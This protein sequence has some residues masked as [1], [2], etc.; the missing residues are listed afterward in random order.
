MAERVASRVFAGRAG[1]FGELAAA[2]ARAA[3]GTPLVVLVGGEAGVGK[4][5]LLSEVAGR[6]A[7]DGARVLWGECVGLEEAAIP[8][9]PVT[10]A[11]SALD[12]GGATAP[13]ATPLVRGP[14]ARPH[15]C[16]LERLAQTSASVPVLLVVEDLHWADRS[17]LDCVTFLARR[18]RRE[19]VLVVASFRSD[20]VAR[21]GGLRRFLADIST[22][23]N[24]RRL[25]LTGLTRDEMRM[26]IGGIAGTPASAEL[27]DALF[28][29]SG[30]NPFF[31]EELLA[32][33]R[34]GSAAG[35]SLALRDMLLARI[36]ALP[37]GAQVVVRVAAVGGRHVHH[38]LLADAAGLPEAQLT[39]ALRAAVRH[40]VLVARDDDFAFRHALV[41]EVAYGELLPGE[42]GRL[43]AAF[44]GALEGRPDVSGGSPA[45]VAAEVAHHWL[46]AGDHHRA[47]RATV[48]AGTEAERVGALAE[49]ARQHTRALALW[50]AVP[51]AER[52]AGLDQAGL[53]ARAANAIAS[54]ADAAEAIRL[55][56]R[57]IELVDAEA[58]PLR[59]ALLHERR[60]MFLWQLE[61]GLEGVR[62]FERAVELIPS[63]PPSA[64]WATALGRLGWILMLTGEHVRSRE[65]C[66]A[67]VAVAR[68]VGARVAEADALAT[69]GI[70]LGLL[71]DGPG[72]L[73]CLRRA[74]ALAAEAGDSEIL[75]QT[76]IALSAGLMRDGQ[77]ADAVEVALAGA[78]AS[79]RA[80]LDARE[81]FCLMQAAEAA[82]ELGSW[83]TVD[84]L[85]REV[86]ARELTGI[87]LTNAHHMAG[88]LAC[89]RGDL[90][91][92]EAH[93]A[94]ERDAI[95]AHPT[96]ESGSYA[97]EAE[98]ELALAQRRPKAASRAAERGTRV[99]TADKERCL[100]MSAI[101][102]RA[103]ADLAEI[104]RA[105]RDRPA[106]L[107]ARQQARAFHDLGGEL[108]AGAGHAALSALIEAEHARAEGDSDPV[109]WDA[110]ARAWEGRSAP[111]RAAYARR[112]QAEAALEHRD[113][114]QAA[115]ALRAA[116][117]TAVDLG[118]T[119]L[120]SDIER[121]ARRA[122][123]DL[124]ARE[125]NG[126][127][128]AGPGPPTSA[129]GLGLT[130]REIEVLEHLALGQTNRQI[131]EELFISVKT[132]GIHV[133]H[134]LGKL[135]A[136]NR[137]EAAAIAH[138]LRLVP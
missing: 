102:V 59:A 106:E 113:R 117:T 138:R 126:V 29:R 42:R 54:T 52:V 41:Q 97:L 46:R 62:D 30:G 130:S 43:H 64:E 26:Q 110:A 27:S 88:V 49:A 50:D 105:R 135:G 120:R 74:R 22:A 44:A 73:T 100:L 84:R 99:Y 58:Q 108:A 67:A 136:T 86:L 128:D 70:D 137:G 60:G 119:T 31:A 96:P 123:I 35:L 82:F 121:L 48:R 6:A 115:L 79:R 51:D 69:L 16:V 72:G 116:H 118:A 131:A 57:A 1:E 80:G 53:L 21:R 93:L 32:V 39:E 7:D 55:I 103:E 134:I 78:E 109:R 61:R 4:T 15:A 14:P 66:E 92:A 3:D 76:A 9:L 65:R 23:R 77:L 36:T 112:H 10:E 71:G 19:R 81:G 24:V 34:R 12:D 13:A 90:D 101:G 40:H 111:Y 18:L 133:S 11:L 98:A 95:G 114:P 104:A 17:T 83:E 129:D 33:A 5:R 38:R 91:A 75:T 25:E 122:R 89:A 8:L 132:A 28:D 20:E 124:R 68:A 127:V 45:T 47:L 2:M 107:A 94:A 87:T 37:A 63:A 56:D 125:P 85:A